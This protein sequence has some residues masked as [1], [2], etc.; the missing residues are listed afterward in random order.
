[1]HWP[2]LAETWAA[3]WDAHPP[4][5]A[6]IGL[7]VTL[8]IAGAMLQSRRHGEDL[9][10]RRAALFALGIA[11]LLFALQSPLHHLSDEY[12]FSAHMLQH[13]LLTLVAPPLLLIGTPAWMVRDALDRRWL[14]RAA[15]SRG[16][17]L[18][19]FGAFNVLFAFIHFPAIY[20]AVFGDELSHRLAHVGLL[21]TATV[22][23]LPLCSPA[24][25]L[26]P[27]LPRPGQMLYCFVQTLPGSMVGSLLTLADWV[28][29]DHYG[30]RPLELG[31]SPLQDQQLGGLLMWVVG[32]SFFLLVLTVIFFV[33]ADQEEKTAYG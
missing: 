2:Q 3:G 31:I 8:Y 13:Q 23:W 7:L 21:A 15:H 30:S 20:D 4:L 24:P 16:F 12:L 14:V 29:Y 6:G 33:W 10:P 18:L 25:E 32:G 9:S 5:L 22:T 28:L 11:V 27:R 26:I 19:A 17:P 1:M